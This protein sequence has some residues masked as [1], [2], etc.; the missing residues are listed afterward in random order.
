[1]GPRRK[2]PSRAVRAVPA[3]RVVCSDTPEFS[4][5]ATT[6]APATGLPTASIAIPSMAPEGSGAREPVAAS[7][8]ARP[9]TG[10]AREYIMARA[11]VHRRDHAWRG[12]W[13]ALIPM[14]S[15][16]V[17]REKC[18][19]PRAHDLIVTT[20]LWVPG[21][22]GIESAW[23]HVADDPSAINEER[24]RGVW[25][26]RDAVE[27]ES[28]Q[29]TPMIIDRGREAKAERG[30][31]VAHLIHSCRPRARLRSV[32][33]DHDQALRTEFPV[34]VIE[35]GRCSPAERASGVHEEAE[36]DDLPT[37]VRKPQ[38][39]A[40][41]PAHLGPLRGRGPDD[42]PARALRKG[43]KCKE[44]GQG[45]AASL[46]HDRSVPTKFRGASVRRPAAR[47]L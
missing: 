26:V 30:H 25:G 31:V 32:Q 41:N 9:G 14:A 10:P 21:V 27:P 6:S 5:T 16:S 37:E 11:A 3:A 40:L 28:P 1:M 36:E 47:A 34:E 4:G 2:R 46:R 22:L 42:L 29:G 7:A 45:H 38:Q 44:D 19:N 13:R 15:S 39:P 18:D 12:W 17:F 43:E 20:A 23:L 8:A 24:R 35:R 33:P